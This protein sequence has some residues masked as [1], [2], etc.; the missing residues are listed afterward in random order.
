[1]VTRWYLSCAQLSSLSAIAVPELWRAAIYDRWWVELTC[2]GQQRFFRADKLMP[3]FVG[4]SREMSTEQLP[5]LYVEYP[6]PALP[7]MPFHQPIAP[8]ALIGLSD[9]RLP[10]ILDDDGAGAIPVPYRVPSPA[11]QALE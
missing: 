6:A 10:V 5:P 1:M 7:Y 8:P 9:I 11:P 4:L 2:E 3:L